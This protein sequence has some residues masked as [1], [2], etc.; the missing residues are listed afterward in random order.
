MKKIP[1]F[2][3]LFI[4]FLRLLHTSRL[5]KDIQ[6]NNSIRRHFALLAPFPAA[7]GIRISNYVTFNQQSYY[8]LD[9]FQGQI[10]LSKIL[11]LKFQWPEG[12]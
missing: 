10:R 8:S 6:Y 12:S 2:Q 1:T 11:I 4:D 3:S 9:N 7:I 5:D